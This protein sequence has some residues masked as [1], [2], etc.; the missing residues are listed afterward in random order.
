VEDELA[1]YNP[2]VPSGRDLSA[3]LMLEWDDPAARAV[4]LRAL[5]G[6]E[7]HLWLQVGDTA[8]L[9]A[10]FDGA[11][12]SDGRISS[13]QYVRWALDEERTAFLKGEGTVVR[14]KL[15]HPEYRASAVLSEESRKELA[16]DLD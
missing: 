9:L 7:D 10:T 5:C 1:A 6:I 16:G 14:V 13:V 11:Q 2:L 4:H 8:P 15:D 12:A 3:T